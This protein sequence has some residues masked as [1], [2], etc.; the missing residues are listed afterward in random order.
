MFWLIKFQDGAGR[1]E[2]GQ[3]LALFTFLVSPT[4]MSQHEAFYGRIRFVLT[5]RMAFGTESDKTFSVLRKKCGR[6][7]NAVAKVSELVAIDKSVD[8]MEISAVL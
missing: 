2:L 7:T 5:L 3:M 6:A 1:E 4:D 8:E